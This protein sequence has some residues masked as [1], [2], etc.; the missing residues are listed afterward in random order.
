MTIKARYAA[1]V[2]AAINK[3]HEEGRYRTFIDIERRKGSFPN[4]VWRKPLKPQAPSYI[5]PRRMVGTRISR[6][7]RNT[8]Q[9]GK[10]RS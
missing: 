2:D 5:S 7:S 3:L 4:A 8:A 10:V 1:A 6:R 9:I